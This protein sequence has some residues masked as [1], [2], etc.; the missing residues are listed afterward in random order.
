MKFPMFYKNLGK[1]IEIRSMY[2]RN[3][4]KVQSEQIG[5]LNEK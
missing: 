3:M 1:L 2:L 5:Y 4:V